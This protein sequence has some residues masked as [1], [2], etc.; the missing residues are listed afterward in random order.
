[1]IRFLHAADL[2]LDSPFRDLTA[3]QAAQRRREQRELPARL[4][5]AA[6]ETGAQVV[7]LAGDLFD[8]GQIYRETAQALAAALGKMDCPVFL[9]PGN[10]DPMTARSPY[11]A[12]TWPDNVH[13]FR[14]QAVESVPLPALG[15]VVHGCAF[16]GPD[17]EDDPL[18]GFTVPDDGLIHVMVAHGDVGGRRY[19][20]I[21]PASIAR[22]GLDYLALGHIHAPSGLKRE[23]ETFWAYPGCPEGRGF[24]ECGA[25]GVLAGTVDRGAVTARFVP[26]CARRYERLDAPLTGADSPLEA[27]RA[28]L[29]GHEA[30]ICRL[31]FTGEWDAALDLTALEREL[32]GACWSLSLRDRTAPRRDLWA[33]AGEDSLTGL[34]LREMRTRLEH[35]QDDDARAAAELAVR[36]GLAALEGEEDCRP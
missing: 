36:F 12:L 5:E 7:F 28:A 23:G 26:L 32:A 9:A 13:I 11:A 34:F 3:D 14:S 18:A 22:S 15:C 21:A 8:G 10:H 4:A 29:R 25:R 30:D 6:R 17:R 20:P 16:T 2:H 1:M 24:D 27:A 33:R 31:T 35:A 19:G